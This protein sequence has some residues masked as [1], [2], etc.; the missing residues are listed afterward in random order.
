MERSTEGQINIECLTKSKI[1][2]SNK[3]LI[4]IIETVVYFVY[5]L[6]SKSKSKSILLQ[7]FVNISNN[8]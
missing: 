2:G 1:Q 8:S 6:V 7:R 3:G 5:G 4:A